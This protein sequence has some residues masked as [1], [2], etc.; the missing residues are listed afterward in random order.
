MADLI[1]KALVISAKG[2]SVNVKDFGATGAYKDDTAAIQSAIDYI[3]SIGGGEVIVP[4]G[5]YNISATIEVK[6]K[7]HLKCAHGCTIRP[8]ADVNMIKLRKNAQISGARLDTYSF[9]DFNKCC[10]YVDGSD[11]F[12]F[13]HNTSIKSMVLYGRHERVV[14]SKEEDEHSSTGI[15][16]YATGNGN[17]V[18]GV[19]IY[20]INIIYFGKAIHLHAENAGDD[21]SQWVNGNQFDMIGFS[22]NQYDIYTTGSIYR[23]PVHN[24]IYET[25]GNIFTNI[26]IQPTENITKK[27]FYINGAYNRIIAKVWDIHVVPSRIL[28]Q[29][30]NKT[31]Y[32]IISS[33]L[34]KKNV[35]DQG[36]R[37]KVDGIYESD[38]SF[39]G[40]MMS[41]TI[42]PPVPEVGM[43]IGNQDDFLAFA[44]KRFTVSQTGGPAPE[45][46]QLINAF[47]LSPNSAAKY[48]AS[49]TEI[50][51]IVI[52]ILFPSAVTYFSNFGISFGKWNESPKNIKLQKLYQGMW[53][54]VFDYTNLTAKVHIISDNIPYNTEGFRI[55]LSGTNAAS[56]KLRITRIFGQCADSVGAAYLQTIG[57]PVYGTIDMRDNYVVVGNKTSL[58]TASAAYRG[59]LISV[60]GAT[61]VEDSFYVCAKESNDAY[62]WKKINFTL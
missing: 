18:C 34:E 29:L 4:P 8:T 12:A 36:T 44:N 48:D 27:C 6:P 5:N 40:T 43:F 3:E 55:T 35:T 59:H 11:K 41:G 23:H 1:T 24:G 38:D 53:S 32:T 13:N 31:A 45:A 9:V 14:R 50:N 46:G 57:G 58:P 17:N 2:G 42:P 25:S 39:K 60:R 19:H 26:Q 49:T 61:G 16:L 7:V 22:G 30:T 52:E 37:N 10:I 47:N 56:G 15:Y 28:A 20:D 33:N 54:D 62:I 51:P 21:T